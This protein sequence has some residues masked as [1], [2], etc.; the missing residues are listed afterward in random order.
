[1]GLLDFF[2]EKPADPEDSRKEREYAAARDG[3][4]RILREGK[5]DDEV[6]MHLAHTKKMA[7][8]L[9]ELRRAEALREVSQVE[10]KWRAGGGTVP[11]EFEKRRKI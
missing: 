7:Q 9:S 11:H 8:D 3:L 10:G 4:N 5:K 2:R 6:E 1:M